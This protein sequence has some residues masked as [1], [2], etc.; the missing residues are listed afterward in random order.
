MTSLRRVPRLAVPRMACPRSTFADERAGIFWLFL[1]VDGPSRPRR[2][3]RPSTWRGAGLTRIAGRD[4]GVP[5]RDRRLRR[6]RRRGLGTALRDSRSRGQSAATSQRVW[7]R[8]L[9]TVRCQALLARFAGRSR[10]QFG[11]ES[12]GSREALSCRR[13]SS[14]GTNG[15]AAHSAKPVYC[16]ATHRSQR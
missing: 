7:R 5:S 3:P 2:C 4:A 13:S 6:L 9:W 8:A 12:K 15:G 11:C 1:G 14:I 16:D 10:R